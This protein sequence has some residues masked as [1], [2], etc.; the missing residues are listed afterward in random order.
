MAALLEG[1]IVSYLKKQMSRTIEMKNGAS[2]VGD[3]Q[4]SVALCVRANI[5]KISAAKRFTNIVSS[6]TSFANH[7]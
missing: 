3:D 2:I 1:I 5:N 4:L 7:V 6:L